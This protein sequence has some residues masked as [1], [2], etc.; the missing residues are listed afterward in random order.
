MTTVYAIDGRRVQTLEDFWRVVGE[1]VNGPGGY[2]GRNLDAL[3]DCL[4]GGMG[5]P[6]DD[7]YVFEWRYHEEC[8][9]SCRRSCAPPGGVTVTACSRPMW[10][11]QSVVPSR[12]RCL[13]SRSRQV[14][15]GW[16]RCNPARP[17][18]V[19]VASAIAWAAG[20]LR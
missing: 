11:R 8:I 2:F 13:T 6:E 20:R 7:D 15:P 5:A 18:R 1:A 17:R 9:R 14:Q 12:V 16:N 3:H 4:H 19:F 10:G